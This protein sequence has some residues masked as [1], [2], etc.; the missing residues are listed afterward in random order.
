MKPFRLLLSWLAFCTLV[1]GG[2]ASTSPSSAEAEL[3]PIRAGTIARLKVDG[4]NAYLNG[5]PVRSGSY[6]ADGDTVSTGPR[7]SAMLVLNEG[8]YIQLDENTDPLFKQG[9]C[10]LMK[11]FRGRVVFHNIKCQ[12]FEDGLKMA[13]VARSFVHIMSSEEESRVTVIAG[14]V[15]MRSPSPA[16]LGADMEY[17]A[18]REGAVQVA[19]LTPEETLARI[20]WTRNYFHSP[21]AQQPGGLSPMGAAAV[22]GAIGGLLEIL[23]KDRDRPERQE[24]PPR[25]E[26]LPQTQP[27][28][29][30]IPQ[31]EPLPPAQPERPPEPPPPPP[32]PQPDLRPPAPPPVQS[33]PRM[34]PPPNT[35]VTP[36]RDVPPAPAPTDQPVPAAEPTPPANTDATPLPNTDATPPPNTDATPPPAVT[37]PPAAAPAPPPVDQPVPAPEPAPP[38]NTDA[39]PPSAVPPPPTPAEQPVPAIKEEKPPVIH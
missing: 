39:P 9:A 30:P 27:E 1:L 29:P 18:T 32:E 35:D 7:T 13:G 23:R 15:E 4:P 6:V 37:P 10:L 12:E 16:I 28:P 20:A 17:V 8:G 3:P 26:T 5:Q 2:C 22:G 21:A 14:E 24:P 25:P 38:A 19:Q 34:E 31:P 36:P 11:I 33:T